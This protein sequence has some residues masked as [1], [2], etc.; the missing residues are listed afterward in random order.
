MPTSVVKQQSELDDI[1]SS[2]SMVL[3][4]EERIHYS[5]DI[6]KVTDLVSIVPSEHLNLRNRVFSRCEVLQEEIPG[7]NRDEMRT[8]LIS[9]YDEISFIREWSILVTSVD[10]AIEQCQVIDVV[11]VLGCKINAFY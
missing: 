1:L 10:V 6:I 2:L 8:F 3:L 9:I 5:M 7:S 4:I 11:L